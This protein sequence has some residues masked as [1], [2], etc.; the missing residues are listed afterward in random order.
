MK[1]KILAWALALV[2]ALGCVGALAENAKLTVR[3]TGVVN[4]DADRASIRIGVREVASQV[5]DAQSAINEKMDAVIEKLNEMGIGKENISTSSIGIYPNYDYSDVVEEIV[6]Y[7]AYNTI[8]VITSDVDNVGSY[9]DAAFE[10]GANSLDDVEFSAS[11]TSDAGRKALAIAV[12]NAMEKA[13]VLAEATGAK[14]GGIVE[15]NEGDSD[16]YS[17]PVMYAEED[18]GKGAAT[19]VIASQQ[20]VSALVSVVFELVQEG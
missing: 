3:G 1:R 18:A 9:I 8:L 17:L 7:T 16:I 13:Q 2:M 5:V 20:K 6:G 15:I 19:D 11:D 14:L 10:A 12:Q 4:L